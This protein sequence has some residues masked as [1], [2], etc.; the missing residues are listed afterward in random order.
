MVDEVR[1]LLQELWV[2]KQDIT[3]EKY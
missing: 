3:F 2:D 1:V